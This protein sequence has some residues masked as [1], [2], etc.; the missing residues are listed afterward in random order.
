VKIKYIKLALKNI[1]MHTL[2]SFLTILGI[3]FGVSSVVAMLSISEGARRKT[4]DEIKSLGIN[5][6]IVE[7]IKPVSETQPK[8]GENLLLQRL[9]TIF[10]SYEYGIQKKDMEHIR[11]TFSEVCYVVPLKEIRKDVY[12]KGK[13]VD[14]KVIGVANEYI[15]AKK[16]N[17]NIG[18]FFNELDIKRYK[19]VCVIGNVAKNKLFLFYN[20]IGE[21]IRISN[22]IYEVIGVI[23]DNTDYIYI[24]YTTL[25]ADFGYVVSKDEA[26]G[27]EQVKV[28]IDKLYITVKDVNDVIDVSKRVKTYF[29]KTHPK[30]DFEIKVPL[31]YLRQQEATQKIFKIVMSSIAAISLLVG[32]IGIMNIMLANILERMKEIGTR[33]TLGATKNHIL[34]QFLTES[35]LLT[36]FGGIVGIGFGICLSF[37]VTLY[38]HWPVVIT[39]DSILLA[40]ILSTFVGIIFG[41]YPA[42]KAAK[43]NPIEA[44]RKE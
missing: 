30:N 33:R 4:I 35:I 32:G 28:D 34:L 23:N 21:F 24:P 8:K 38:S 12:V 19:R 18:R 9:L 29:S 5:N 39:L 36:N 1:K 22:C 44:L 43:L 31:E 13:K 26:G 7:S 25:V 6:I 20:P 27:F 2:R 10:T 37:V 16:L 14:A 11:T 3:I 15:L 40:F 41:T 17:M 42:Y